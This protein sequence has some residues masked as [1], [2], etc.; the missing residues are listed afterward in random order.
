MDIVIWSLGPAYAC[1]FVL[2]ATATFW[3]LYLTNEIN[4]GN[5]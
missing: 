1:G 2:G 4:N 5:E 3:L